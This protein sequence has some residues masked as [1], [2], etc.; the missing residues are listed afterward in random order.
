MTPQETRLA[1]V[2]ERAEQVHGVV[3]ERTG[4]VDADWALFYAW[5]LVHWSDLPEIIGSRPAVGELTA[6]LTELD[7]RYRS[8]TPD[9]SWPAFYSRELLASNS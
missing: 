2:L 6:R 7:A 3:T 9:E 4:G 8:G 5:W 1:T